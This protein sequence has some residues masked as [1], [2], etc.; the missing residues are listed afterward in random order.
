MVTLE[1]V[2]LLETKVATVIGFVDQVTAENTLLRGKLDEYKLR[3]DELEALIQHF[4]DDQSRIEEGIISALDRLNQFEHAVEQSLSTVEPEPKKEPVP[5]PAA[6]PVMAVPVTP[7]STATTP[8]VPAAAPTA[9]NTEPSEEGGKYAPAED[10]ADEDFL[11]EA[12]E[13]GTLDGE[14]SGEDTTEPSDPAPDPAELDI[15]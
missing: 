2:R 4:K 5:A 14:F 8:V 12:E 10:E 9:V 6:V 13:E 15:F 11:V 1:Q 7:V 3:I